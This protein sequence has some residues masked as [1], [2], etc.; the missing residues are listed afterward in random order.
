MSVKDLDDVLFANGSMFDTFMNETV[1]AEVYDS[2][3]ST[4]CRNN[5]SGYSCS[6]RQLVF[7]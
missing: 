4:I 5:P 3:K 6:N 1:Y 7:N 2:Y